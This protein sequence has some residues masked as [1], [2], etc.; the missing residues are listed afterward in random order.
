MANKRK[1]M[2]T[3]RQIIQMIRSGMSKRAISEQLGISRTTVKKYLSFVKQ[4]GLSNEEFLSL[5]DKT[6]SDLLTANPPKEK[7]QLTEL[8]AM[9]PIFEKELRRVGVNRWVLWEE[10]KQKHPKGYSYTQFCYH[11]QQWS[12][13]SDVTMH[14]EHKAGDK[15]FV[16]Y[17][18]KNLRIVNRETGEI[19][20]V[21]VFVAILGAS[22]M[23]YVEATFTQGKE[24]FI[25]S[26]G[27]TF[28]YIG[29]VTNAV[30][31][32]N[33]KSAVNE[34]NKYEPLINE[35]FA[36]F[37]LHYNT[38]ILATRSRKP[39]DKALVEKAISIVYS[40]IFA[41]LRDRVFYSLEELNE[42]IR[43]LLK[44]CNKVNFKGRDYSRLDLF[45]S[46]EK[47]AL[48]PLPSEPY[49][50]K[51]FALVKVQKNS[52]IYLSEDKHY[53]SVPFRFIGKRIKVA[54]T[55][56]KVDIY[57]KYQRIAF[58]KRDRRPY[59]YTTIKEHLPSTHQF[60]ADW[61][62]DKFIGW[63]EAYGEDVRS[64]IIEVLNNNQHPE[65]NYKSC[66][67]ILSLEKKYGKERLNN[68][69]KRGSYYSNYSYRVIRNILEKGLDKL[70]QQTIQQKIPLHQNIRGKDYYQ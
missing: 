25:G 39:R 36:C 7:N 67:G 68:A 47:E 38:Y 10:Y 41:P 33:V 46:V 32:D 44:D 58:H 27:R 53:Y 9:F 66:V 2:L 51:N 22:Q 40:R 4:T 12:G 30:I 60:V 56:S 65:Q 24:D 14:F 13:N 11:Y 28:W 52:H 37:G 42:A 62:P 15:L 59:K 19:I 23:I 21:E 48:K 18:G 69:C 5:D 31:P 20:P 57:Y 3:V 26:V 54:Y 35:N 43:E 49:E 61:N 8:I 55:V 50:I 70:Q 1:T 45:N 6:I 17:A 64:Y 29:G 63:A 16:D 34:S